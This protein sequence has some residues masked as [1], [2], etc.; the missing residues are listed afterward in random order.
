[1]NE[2][3][4]INNIETGKKNFLAIRLS[5]DELLKLK[6]VMIDLKTRNQSKA[7]RH[8]INETFN[9]IE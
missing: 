4:I 6:D 2:K 7:V 8:C 9:E 5:D 1:M 3:N